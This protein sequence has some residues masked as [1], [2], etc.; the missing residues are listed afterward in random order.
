MGTSVRMTEKHYGTLLEGA[1]AG[2]ASRLAA[3]ESE[4][5]QAAEAEVGRLAQRRC[6]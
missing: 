6:P 2:I 4:L 1:H 5:E 3:L